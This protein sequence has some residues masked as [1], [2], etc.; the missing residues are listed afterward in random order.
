LRQHLQSLPNTKL[1]SRPAFLLVL[2]SE[3]QIPPAVPQP[4]I[5]TRPRYALYRIQ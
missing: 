4:P 2:K 1:R 5:V 3:S